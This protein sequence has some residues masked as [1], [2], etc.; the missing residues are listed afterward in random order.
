MS[1]PGGAR[2]KGKITGV[3]QAMGADVIR[4]TLEQT[5]RLTEVQAFSKDQWRVLQ[6]ALHNSAGQRKIVQHFGKHQHE[7]VELGID[8]IEAYQALFRQHVQRTDLRIFTYTSSKAPHHRLWILVGMDNGVVALYNETRRR[9]WSLIR[10]PSLPRYL[11][12]GKGWWVEV[13]FG[14]SAVQVE[15]W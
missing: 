2:W 15:K 12:S 5:K 9:H 4:R 13:M 7:F 6:I 3:P 11:A 14:E 8:S 10:P 1:E